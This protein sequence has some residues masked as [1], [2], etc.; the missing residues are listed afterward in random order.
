MR[1]KSGWILCLLAIP[2]LAVAAA[3]D[4]ALFQNVPNPFSEVTTIGFQLPE[5]STAAL[6]VFDI[7]GKI[8]LERKGQY[9]QGYHEIN[10]DNVNLPGNG[11][12][13]YRIETPT[14]T[15]TKK[16]TRI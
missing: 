13:Y 12:F 16:M 6:T 1:S 15:A 2:L 11:I 8:I 4:F 7:S 3:D 14:H 10:I 5:A 9:G